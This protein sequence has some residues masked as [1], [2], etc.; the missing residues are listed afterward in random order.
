[1][2]GFEYAQH[3]ARVVAPVP[4][5]DKLKGVIREGKMLVAYCINGGA[6]RFE[7]LARHG[8]VRRVALGGIRRWYWLAFEHLREE[9]AAAGA[10]VEHGTRLF[11][12]CLHGLYIVP[13][14]WPG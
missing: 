12:L 10:H 4:V 13:R 6:Q 5:D 11:Q 8:E 14:L 2:T 3:F 7:E 9:L 1:M